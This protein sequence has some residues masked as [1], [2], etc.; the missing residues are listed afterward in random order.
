[1]QSINEN[2]ISFIL[3]ISLANKTSKMYDETKISAL[4]PYVN[5]YAHRMARSFGRDDSRELRKD[6]RQ[7]GLEAVL[8]CPAHY[9]KQQCRLAI[10]YG[11]MNEVCRWRWQVDYKGKKYVPRNEPLRMDDGR[12]YRDFGCSIE[13]EVIGRQLLLKF[14]AKLLIRHGVPAVNALAIMLDGSSG[15]GRARLCWGSR[16]AVIARQIGL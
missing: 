1:M 12:E 5:Y 7:A 9:V 2:P 14:T 11:I 8:K 16:F 6:L 13:D 15:T 4:I 10:R 3:Q